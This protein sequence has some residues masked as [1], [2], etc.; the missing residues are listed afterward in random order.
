[1]SEAP[2]VLRVARPGLAAALAAAALHATAA[3]ASLPSSA[4]SSPSGEANPMLCQ[5]RPD[6][7]KAAANRGVQGTSIIDLDFA[8]D[9]TLAMA[10]IAVPSGA[11]P[12][13]ALLDEA[14]LAAVQ[15]CRLARAESAPTTRRLTY[16]WKLDEGGATADYMKG[17]ERAER[18][19]LAIQAADDARLSIDAEHGV[20]AAQ[21][22][23][24]RQY[25]DGER[26]E[27]NDKLASTWFRKA[28]EAGDVD[29]QVYY[30]Q[31]LMAGKGV[32]QDDE[33]GVAWLRKAAAQ[34]S[35]AAAYGLGIFTRAGRGTRASDSEAFRWFLQGARAG[36]LLAILETADAYAK[37]TGTQ[38][39]D[40]Q[41]AH[42]YLL[43]APHSYVAIYRLGLAYRDGLGVTADYERAAFCMAVI[44]RHGERSPTAALATIVPRLDAA[45]MARVQARA[46]A[47]NIGDP[48]FP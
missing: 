36:T 5:P 32:S 23:L 21:L 25:A 18:D 13:H 40:A 31:R 12:E 46:D 11:S 8:T 2:R 35:G 6:Y 48:L 7:P 37:G 3:A 45:T 30:G 9:G 44:G 47:W 17:L 19:R 24:A 26:R 20:V 15:R 41:A 34:G 42:W 1:M 27:G 22:A 28:A 29:A 14:A 4:A 39:D 38:R 16:N 33:A 43:A 10:R